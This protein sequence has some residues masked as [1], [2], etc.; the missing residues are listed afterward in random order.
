MKKEG[1]VEEEEGREELEEDD[2]ELN[3]PSPPFKF[4]EPS[5]SASSLLGS[6][7]PQPSGPGPRSAPRVDSMTD[8]FTSCGH[9]SFQQNKLLFVGRSCKMSSCISEYPRYIP[10]SPKAVFLQV[11]Q[12]FPKEFLE[13]MESHV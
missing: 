11:F 9:L 2:A 8:M 12:I 7:A 4:I 13:S 5:P 10:S 6:G 1:R 3:S